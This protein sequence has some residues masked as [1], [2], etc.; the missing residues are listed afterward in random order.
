MRTDDRV[1]AIGSDQQPS[2]R[3]LTIRKPSN[4]APCVLL[5][6]DTPGAAMRPAFVHQSGQF[7]KQ[8]GPGQDNKGWDSKSLLQFS[9]WHFPQDAPV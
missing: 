4:H 5:N 3:L 9:E 2:L 1:E 7:P 8:I 6:S